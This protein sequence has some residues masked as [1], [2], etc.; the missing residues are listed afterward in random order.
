MLEEGQSVQILDD[1]FFPYYSCLQ[2]LCS[3]RIKN[4]PRRTFCGGFICSRIIAGQL[5]M[6]NVTVASTMSVPLDGIWQMRLYLALTSRNNNRQQV[7]ITMHDYYFSS[8]HDRKSTRVHFRYINVKLTKAEFKLELEQK[9]QE[10]SRRSV[11]FQ[12][13]DKR[14]CLYRTRITSI[15]FYCFR[16]SVYRPDHG[17]SPVQARNWVNGSVTH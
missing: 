14:V 6:K 16:P 15:H 11:A 13:K 5:R 2:I 10:G 17:P 4:G 3:F 12:P 7:G 1:T 8:F 9:T